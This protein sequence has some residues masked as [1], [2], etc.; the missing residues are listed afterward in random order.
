MDITESQKSTIADWVKRGETIA[1]IQ[2]RLREEME[3]SL[4]YM[5]VRFLVDDLNLVYSEPEEICEIEEESAVNEEPIQESDSIE[6]PELVS[7]VEVNVDPVTPP[8]ALV[9]GTV[10]FSDGKQMAWQLSAAGQLG[11]VPGDDPDYRPNP[12]DLQ[13]FQSQLQQVLQ[14]HGY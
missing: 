7:S 8:G 6:E 3:L 2:R 4:T 5:D 14:K 12:E 13:E 1:I 9:C 11:L 10:N